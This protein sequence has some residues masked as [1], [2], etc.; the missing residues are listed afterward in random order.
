[1][2]SVYTTEVS[3]GFHAH[4]QDSGLTYFGATAEE[5]AER[6]QRAHQVFERLRDEARQERASHEQA[7]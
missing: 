5:A 6:T 2:M 7:K 1:M 3:G 4:D